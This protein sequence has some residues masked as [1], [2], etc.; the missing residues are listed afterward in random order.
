MQVALLRYKDIVKLLFD[1]KYK[2]YADFAHFHR[3]LTFRANLSV[4][5]NWSLVPF[6]WWDDPVDFIDR[7]LH[8]KIALI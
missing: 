2:V 5:N 3:P 7:R 6:S 4:K 1:S 8:W